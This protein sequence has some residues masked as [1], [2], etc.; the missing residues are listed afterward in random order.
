VTTGRLT[1]VGVGIKVPAQVT[2][3]VRLFIES[4]AE[5]LYLV[6]DPVAASWI[7][8][9]NPRARAMNGLYSPGEDRALAY[10]AMVEEML[11]PVRR[12]RDVC[13][14]FYGHPGVFVNPSHDAIRRAREEGFE[15]RM[16]PGVSADACLFADLGVDPSEFGCQSYEATDLLARARPI[17]ASAALI[18]WQIGVVGNLTYVPKGDLT[19]IPL[20][21]E[22]L[23]RYYPSD[24]EVVC[25]EA[26][27]YPVCEASIQ[28]CPLSSLDDAEISPMST[29][30]IPPAVERPADPLMRRRLFQADA[31]ND[32]A[33]VS[34]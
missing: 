9:V 17:D 20:L 18:I 22:F 14:A 30:Y 5:V 8:K 26:A 31:V 27:L 15:A 25:Y 33:V 32:A 34:S 23:E 11:K 1:V 6:A 7:C 21:V 13:V 10:A 29:L 28:R 12:G 3:E 16:L 19:H 24:H 2:T 4:A